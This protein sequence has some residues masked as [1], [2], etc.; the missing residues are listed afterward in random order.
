MSVRLFIAFF[1]LC[2]AGGLTGQSGTFVNQIEGEPLVADQEFRVEIN[3]LLEE[4][5][6]PNSIPTYRQFRGSRNR[7]LFSLAQVGTQPVPDGDYTVL[8]EVTTRQALPDR[9]EDPE[10]HLFEFIIDATPAGGTHLIAAD[11]IQNKWRMDVHVI[12]VTRNDG[13]V[14]SESPKMILMG[15]IS[16]NAT[17]CP[18][19]L[20]Q[21]LDPKVFATSED[22]EGK[23]VA[24]VPSVGC[25]TEYDLEYVF[26][27]ENSKSGRNLSNGNG[28]DIPIDDLFRNNST[29]LTSA[30]N[31]FR[32]FNLFRDGYLVVRYRAV[33]YGEGDLRTY[34]R[35][36]TSGVNIPSDPTTHADF[37]I[38]RV[39][40][41]TG[42]NWQATTNFAEE[43]K[44]LPSISYLDGT[45]RARQ[46]LVLQYGEKNGEPNPNTEFAIGQ[47]TVYDAMGRPAASILPAPVYP[48]ANAAHPLRFDP[49]TLAKPVGQTADNI[50][51]HIYGTAQVEAA[52]ECGSEV[53]GTDAGAGKF[54]S[55]SNEKSEGEN[56]YVPD[57]HGYP[58]AVTRYTPDNTGRIRR[59][60]GVGPR[61]QI[62]AH[63]TKYYYGKPAQR[64]LDRL[65][66]VNVGSASHYQKTMVVDPNG[67]ATISYL[68]AKGRTVATALAGQSPANLIPI[69]QVEANFGYRIDPT[70]SLTV[71]FENSSQAADSYEWNFADLGTSIDENPSFTFPQLGTYVVC[72]EAAGPTGRESTCQYVSVAIAPEVRSDTLHLTQGF[73]MAS[74]DVAPADNRITAIFAELIAQDK[75]IYVQGRDSLGG[76]ALFN[77]RLTEEENVLTHM[78]PGRGYMIGVS[79]DMDFAVEG[80]PIDSAFQPTL[81]PGINLVAYLPQ[82][83]T[84]AVSFFASLESGEGNLA[85]ARAFFNSRYWSYRPAYHQSAPFSVENGKAYEILIGSQIDGDNWL[86]ENGGENGGLAGTVYGEELYQL[87]SLDRSPLGIGEENVMTP[88]VDGGTATG[89]TPNY[90]TTDI[91][92]N[93]VYDDRVV[94]TFALLVP[95]T[96]F[97]DL[98]YALKEA[99]YESGC[100][101]RIEDP[102]PPEEQPDPEFPHPESPTSAG[103]GTF[104]SQT[105]TNYID[106][107]F[108]C[109]YDIEIAIAPVSLCDAG[110]FTAPAP[111]KLVNKQLS[112]NTEDCFAGG[113]IDLTGIELPQGEYIITKTVTLHEPAVEA[114]IEEYMATAVCVI[115]Q[116][117]YVD[118]YVAGADVSGCQP[119]DCSDPD[120]S[121]ACDDLCAE[122][123]TPCE[124]L[125]AV[126]EGDLTPGQGQYARFRIEYTEAYPNGNYVLTPDPV[127]EE[128]NAQTY[129][130]SILNLHPDN[131]N[132]RVYQDESLDWSGIEIKINGETK[133]D[134]ADVSL[135]DFIDNFDEKWVKAL[136]PLHPENQL[137][138]WCINN[139][140]S[141]DDAVVGSHDFDETMRSVQT[142]ATASGDYGS[143]ADL[144]GTAIY[145]F[146]VAIANKDPF[147]LAD[148]NGRRDAFLGDPT[149]NDAETGIAAIATLRL[150]ELFG[151]TDGSWTW[152]GL[153]DYQ[154]DI[155]WRIVRD[156]YLGRKSTFVAGERLADNLGAASRAWDNLKWICLPQPL[157]QEFNCNY[158]GACNTEPLMG[159][160]QARVTNFLAVDILAGDL[161]KTEEDLLDPD[162]PFGRQISDVSDN[163]ESDCQDRCAQ[164]EA[165]WR[166]Q[167]NQ[168]PV[169]ANLPA[170]D[171]AA[172]I[173]ELRAICTA[174]C[175]GGE[176]FGSSTVP[177]NVVFTPGIGGAT[178]QEVLAYYIDK[179]N[180]GSDACNLPGNCGSNLISFP[181]PAGQD[182]Y[183]GTAR[184]PAEQVPV[185]LFLNRGFLQSRLD[186]LLDGCACTTCDVPEKSLGT[187]LSTEVIENM[188]RLNRMTVTDLNYTLTMIEQFL[189]PSTDPDQLFAT[190]EDLLLP[191]EFNP[192]GN[193]CAYKSVLQSY[194]QAA[195]V[196]CADSTDAWNNDRRADH[197]NARLGYNR[198]WEEYATVL[199]AEASS[200]MICAE[201][202]ATADPEDQPLNC[203]EETRERARQDALAQHSRYLDRRRTDFER[204]YRD[205]C[206]GNVNDRLD[207]RYPEREYH[208]TLY[209]YD[210]AGNLAMTVPPDGVEPLPESKHTDVKTYRDYL[211][212]L[213]EYGNSALPAPTL[214]GH[215][216][217]T[218]YRYNSFNEV[219]LSDAPDKDPARTWYDRLGRPV[220]SMDGRQQTLGLLSYT[221]YD[222]LGR[223]EEVGELPVNDQQFDA[224][225][226]EARDDKLENA[227]AD[228]ADRFH[229]TKTWYTNSGLSYQF[230]NDDPFVR[231]NRVVATTYRAEPDPEA[232]QG[233]GYDYQTY[234]FASHYHYDIAGNVDKLVQDFPDL[235]TYGQRYK[236]LAYTY[237]LISGNVHYLHYQLG[238]PD[239]FSYHYKYDKL[240]RLSEVFSSEIETEH[241]RSNIWKR[242]ASYTYYDHGPLKRT[243]L[244]QDGLQGLDYAYTLQGW[245]KGVNG[246]LGDDYADV[247]APDM[248][249]DGRDATGS[250][251]IGQVGNIDLYRYANQYFHQDYT[252]INANVANPF[253]N[254]LPPDYELF[255]GNIVRHYKSTAADK[256]RTA[257][258]VGEY[259][260]LNRL[261]YGRQEFYGQ[262]TR[263][264]QVAT[265]EGTHLLRAVEAP[266][267][268][269]N[270][271]IRHLD[272][273]FGTEA[274]TGHNRLQYTYIA[275]T[276]LLEAVTARAGGSDS[277]RP[278]AFL[279]GEHAYNYDKSG[280]LIEE[281]SPAGRK[282]ITWNP[283]GKVTDVTHDRNGFDPAPYRSDF[284]Y[285]PDQQRWAKLRYR[286][287]ATDNPDDDELEEAT[288]YVRDAQGNTL[289][290][291][292]LGGN[293]SIAIGAELKWKQQYL[294][295]SSRLGE[296][297]L[298]RG[299]T[300]RTLTFGARTYELTNHLGNVVTTFGEGLVA[301]DEGTAAMP[302]LK[303]HQ[304]Y[305]AFGL[306]LERERGMG[307][308]SYRYAFNGKEKD[309][310]GEW[311]TGTTAYDYGFRIYNP[312][313]A[314]FL[315]LD[316]LSAAIP[317]SSPYSFASN[318]PISFIDKKGLLPKSESCC[319]GDDGV[320]RTPSIADEIIPSL[321]VN[322]R[323]LAHN[324]WRGTKALWTDD[325]DLPPYRTYHAGRNSYGN[326]E[327]TYTEAQAEPS[328]TEKLVSNTASGVG[329]MLSLPGGS[330]VYAGARVGPAWW[331]FAKNLATKSELLADGGQCKACAQVIKEE[332]GGIIVKI[333]NAVFPGRAGI[334]DVVDQSGQTIV[335]GNTWKEHFAVFKDGKFYDGLTGSEGLDAD[336]YKELFLDWD[337]LKKTELPDGD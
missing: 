299:L 325:E 282:A 322:V 98:C 217:L 185:F 308:G 62:G 148:L 261:R 333:E 254:V 187:S 274:N 260:Q 267:F 7:L 74:L 125:Y 84:D 111:L 145:N 180:T 168:C 34:T 298:D 190:I 103:S 37:G 70:D 11:V 173:A 59:Q 328:L 166:A 31:N 160:Y 54:F 152:A 153:K 311:G 210:Q 134:L 65:F 247:A 232:P 310:S 43:A 229:V 196:T 52:G 183:G 118:N 253:D 75:L 22:V 244:G 113:E 169:L 140:D 287:G 255:N 124:S 6:D 45:M 262:D 83:S 337:Y 107:C 10:T 29:R 26:Y 172:M 91:T 248:N 207:L 300:E 69:S 56:A 158:D 15:E 38:L 224:L 266:T 129:T 159:Y 203:E 79:E 319:V 170:A 281:T 327:L 86:E 36:S 18:L 289:A 130:F 259:D 93:V 189:D 17:P 112:G 78:E 133:E 223:P 213:H 61:L 51:F 137:Y 193:F 251:L 66:G 321:V 286:A 330:G 199:G 290:T 221:L 209:Y 76:L 297:T 99:T 197:L 117:T 105:T 90:V 309:D 233:S 149:V 234:D 236:T 57:A 212:D 50:P 131:P 238:Q 163:Y 104:A 64:E 214:P 184:I 198:S 136:L 291:Y 314:R 332:I 191:A 141:G 316:P 24:T 20:S 246:S 186:F 188:A 200:C 295:G 220:L 195:T 95:Q 178:F 243:V 176:P 80:I 201:P 119:C 42:F 216:M 167:I 208:Y 55:S 49:K 283:Y 161:P 165:S 240:N 109:Y 72:L 8:V 219:T 301:Y 147:M 245:I 171:L 329:V 320:L 41:Q 150:T 324:V 81:Y 25:A 101:P 175:V 277:W 242:D 285:G 276:N 71:S 122:L 225:L 77:P 315:S 222:N 194:D 252:P 206:L 27:D 174:G 264:G 73:N 121:Q 272:R 317:Q 19:D 280:N 114:A 211:P 94:T 92:N 53:M 303:S 21:S 182:F 126:M 102:N 181:P 292:E 82:N 279:V 275:R 227:M 312:G 128:D 115:P 67:Q 151:G 323:Q 46:N 263:P 154:K 265:P 293:A 157:C 5:N 144:K 205:H 110:A 132:L 87:G 12:S 302:D 273:F 231:R 138:D 284:G 88:T 58:F 318:N 271:N 30:D 39:G 218:H 146:V 249:M 127:D 305:L 294:F 139:I 97:Y 306:S 14:G 192:G 68:D 85:F 256:F 123:P 23:I 307:L 162:K 48:N 288:Y 164:Y 9:F 156:L 40:H 33:Q 202:P 142:Y 13:P 204:G 278:F 35:W 326:F 215:G 44:Q 241:S 120:R 257:A 63:D 3:D 237:D 108:E 239:Q 16:E 258:L 177:A 304:D 89:S 235:G 336:S 331:P 250:H 155:A 32:L 313:I 4:N 1:I 2:T 28:N 296:V 96:D 135:S 334:G 47:Q 230:Q 106:D 179:H 100:C 60:G 228:R 143:S 269:G 270:G 116:D 335:T 226:I 268:D